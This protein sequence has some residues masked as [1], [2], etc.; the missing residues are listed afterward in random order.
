MSGTADEIKGRVKQAAADLTDNEELEREGEADEAEG[1]IKNFIDDAKEKAEDLV[2]D[3]R[4]RF[5][6]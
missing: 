6:S 1:K 4:D 5:K 3:V 2:D